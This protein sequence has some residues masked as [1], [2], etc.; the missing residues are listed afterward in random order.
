MTSAY[1]FAMLACDP[2]L[3][4]AEDWVPRDAFSQHPHRGIETVT[5]VL[6]GALEHFDSAGNAGCLTRLSGPGR[7]AEP[8]QASF[9]TLGSMKSAPDSALTPTRGSHAELEPPN[10]FAA[11]SSAGAVH[12]GGRARASPDLI[13]MRDLKL[14]VITSQHRSLRQAAEAINIRQSTLSRRL[15][16]L[17][18]RLG[19]HAAARLPAISPPVAAM[20]RLPTSPRSAL[21]ERGRRRRAYRAPSIP[22]HLWVRRHGDPHGSRRA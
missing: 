22:S 9:P 3:L 10:Q 13:E 18:D 6:D 11:P 20:N 1:L 16:E 2:F 14:A 8:W 5:L 21:P 4:M 7:S 17:E 15:R 19:A 12:S